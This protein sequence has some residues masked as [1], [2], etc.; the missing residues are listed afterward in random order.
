MLISFVIFFADV[1]EILSG[2][3]HLEK[4]LKEVPLEVRTR[5]NEL[6]R[7]K[8]TCNISNEVESK[9]EPRSP[10]ETLGDWLHNMPSICSEDSDLK[11]PPLKD[12]P[13]LGTDI[14][15]IFLFSFS[16]SLSLSLS[17]SLSLSLS[18]SRHLRADFK[19][20]CTMRRG[21]SKNRRFDKEFRG[22]EYNE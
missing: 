9:N 19:N 17:P 12:T 16:L 5:V 20:L 6:L 3:H 7:L 14:Q 10:T 15:G 8:Q 2:K 13:I 22:F 11:N 18:L 4:E 1:D 21:V